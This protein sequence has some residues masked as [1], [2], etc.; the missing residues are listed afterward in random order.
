MK[1]EKETILKTKWNDYPNDTL[2]LMSNDY[3]RFVVIMEGNGDNLLPEDEANGYKDY[4]LT[5]EYDL[6]T[7]EHVDGAQWME[8]KLIADI[9]YTIE[10]VITRNE[11]DADK[12]FILESSI[13]EELYNALDN[14]STYLI[15]VLRIMR[16]LKKEEHK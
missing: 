16:T 13:G 14:I 3:S 5:D 11:F 12:F 9:D 7:K 6:D 1:D 10:G 15:S 8:E 2:Y 4:W